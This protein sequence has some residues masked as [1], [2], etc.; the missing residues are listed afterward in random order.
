M[1]TTLNFLFCYLFLTAFIQADQWAQTQFDVVS[2]RVPDRLCRVTL[3]QQELGGEIDR[4]IRNLVYS[5][6]MV[7][8]LD[9]KWL[10][11]FR[12]R[13]ERGGASHVYYGIGNRERRKESYQRDTA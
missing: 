4:R 8:D 12:H 13:T 1:K 3:N 11:H 2:P 7:I 9:G 5:N 6:Y 10:N